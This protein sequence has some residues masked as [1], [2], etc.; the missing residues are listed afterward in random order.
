MI[1]LPIKSKIM[2]SLLQD[3]DLMK[4]L[5]K[6]IGLLEIHGDNIGEKWDSLEFY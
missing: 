2:Q 3:M 6:N 4:R 1:H 5:N